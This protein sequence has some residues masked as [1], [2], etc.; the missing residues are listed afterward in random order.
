MP[1][2]APGT[3][4]NGSLPLHGGATAAE[5]LGGGAAASVEFTETLTV[6]AGSPLSVS[7]TREQLIVAVGSSPSSETVAVGPDTV[8][9][10]APPLTTNFSGPL[11][12]LAQVLAS[13]GLSETANFGAPFS[14]SVSV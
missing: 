6:C 5:I 2:G 8:S 10:C 9:T 1:C 4:T 14:C 3:A 12:A 7:T 11:N 13:A